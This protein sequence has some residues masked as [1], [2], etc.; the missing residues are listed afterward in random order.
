MNT[1]NHTLIEE[2]ILLGFFILQK[3]LASQGM[4]LMKSKL[5]V[6]VCFFLALYGSTAL[7]SQSF[8]KNIKNFIC[9]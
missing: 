5:S 3:Q 2:K 6:T 4:F 7:Q 9:K 8:I 1:A